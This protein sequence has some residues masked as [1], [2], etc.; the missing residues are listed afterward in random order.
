MCFV[1]TDNAKWGLR[2]IKVKIALIVL[3]RS[4]DLFIYSFI[5]KNEPFWSRLIEGI[6]CILHMSERQLSYIQKNTSIG[7]HYERDLH[8]SS[9][10]QT[11]DQWRS[12]LV[13][14]YC[15]DEL[16]K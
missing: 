10:Q 14:C 13:S 1:L 5:F 15:F 9:R 7:R 6:F 2:P 4:D 11:H 12:Q 3:F 16:S 8:N